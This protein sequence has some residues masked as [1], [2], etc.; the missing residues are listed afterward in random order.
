MR[1][2]L[3]ASTAI[4]GLATFGLVDIASAQASAAPQ[5]VVVTGSRIA[6]QDYVADSPIVT[7]SAKALEQSGAVTV[8]KLLNELPQFVPAATDTSN[9]PSNG[10]QANIALRGIGT[11][12]TLVLVDGRRTTPSNATGVVDI[13]TIP[14]AL[15]D[16]IEVITGGASATY[17]SDAI[18]GVVNFKLKHH[19]QGMQVDAQYGKSGQDDGATQNISV[20]LG[21]NFADDKGNAI[22]SLSFA[23]REAIFNGSRAFSAYSGGSGTYPTGAYTTIGTNL[24]TAAAV[25]AVF[26]KYG[27]AAGTVAP[28]ITRL[29]FNNDGTLFSNGI[30]YKGPTTIDFSTIAA[31]VGA[32]AT[33]NYDTGALNYLQLPLTRYNAFARSEYDI[34]SHLKATA[35]FSFTNYRAQTELAP[36][37]A[38]SSPAAG[39]T[40]FFVP[41][42]NPFVPADLKTI[43]ASRANPLAPFLLSKRFTELGGRVETDEY[44][45][46]NIVTGLEGD[47]PNTDWN[48]SGYLTYGRMQDNAVQTG[49]V[50]HQAVRTLLEAADGGASTCTGGYNP[51]GVQPIS[52]SCAAYIG[53]TTKNATSLDERVA[54]LN[55]SGSLFKVPAGAVK[56]ALGTDYRRD[57]FAFIPDSVLSTRDIET[58]PTPA[59]PLTAATGLG[60]PA[61]DPAFNQ[62]T[63]GVVGFNAQNPLGGATDVYELYG[64]LL[65]PILKDLPF[66]KAL[67]VDLAYR[68]SDYNTVG[69]VQTYKADGDW[70]DRLG[71]RS[72][73]R[74]FTRRPCAEHRRTL[75]AAEPELP[76]HRPGR[77]RLARLGRPLRR[78]QRLPQGRR[79]SQCRRSP[80]PLPG[81]GRTGGDHRHLHLHPVAGPIDDRRQP[82]PEAGNRRHLHHRRRL[83]LDVRY[84]AVPQAVG[85]DRLLRHQGHQR[86]GHHHRR[87]LDLEVLQRRWIQP[88]LHEL[89]QLLPVV[90]A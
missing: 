70:E 81:A 55:L 51:F 11:V 85:L 60:N 52:A 31:G 3:L 1:R 41:V 33:G 30:D 86:G 13:N 61:I 87:H 64:E 63:P 58:H 78:H 50:S 24:P 83:V 67:N 39:N 34:N 40:G 90:H 7:V 57:D 53:R 82:E 27:V 35:Q 17:G 5:E 36:S 26:A 43:L 45:V 74:L 32:V 42:T 56:F 88:D 8:E 25:N 49:N 15:I 68:Y 18:A 69:G 47:V 75:R 79:R 37:P 71:L 59:I 23:N 22:V 21:G 38:A 80:H 12:R 19:F 2:R 28:S 6:R 65:I 20:L 62:N 77:G 89:E 73:R 4:A 54:E 84:A 44:T 9:N 72:A 14:A 66:I 10:G 76:R 46:Y 48:W 16:G 29:G